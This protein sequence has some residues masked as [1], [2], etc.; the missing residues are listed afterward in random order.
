MGYVLKSYLV[1]DCKHIIDFPTDSNKVVFN[2]LKFSCSKNLIDV[3]DRFQV[4]KSKNTR[5][6]K[7]RWQF[8][9][10]FYPQSKIIDY[11]NSKPYYRHDFEGKLEFPILFLP[12]G[13][14]F[15]GLRGRYVISANHPARYYRELSFLLE[16]VWFNEN[17]ALSFYIEN[18]PLNNDPLKSP[19]GLSI[20]GMRYYF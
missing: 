17:A 13:E 3:Q 9:Y 16:A 5:K 4:N 7:L 12:K 6:R 8:I 15:S 2:R 10:G 1:H 11:L 18:I 19:E 14:I 20:I